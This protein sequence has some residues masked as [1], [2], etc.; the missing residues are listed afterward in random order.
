MPGAGSIFRRLFRGGAKN[1]D[2]AAELVAR[3]IDDANALERNIADR[4]R[5]VEEAAQNQPDLVP[6]TERQLE[7][8]SIV[9][10]ESSPAFIRQEAR[11]ELDDIVRAADT[12]DAIDVPTFQYHQQLQQIAEREQAAL[13]RYVNSNPDLT[14]Q[15]IEQAREEA[16]A[17]VTKLAEDLR[18]N[19]YGTEQAVA[20][21]AAQVDEAVQTQQA[22]NADVAAEQQA[23]TEPVPGS[24]A[25]TPEMQAN[26][27]YSRPT[28][29]EE[30]YAS[31]PKFEE[32][33]RLSIP[34]LISPDRIIRENITRPGENLVN[35]AAS[36]MQTGNSRIGRFFGRMGTGFSRELGIVPDL[37]TARMQLRGGIEKGKVYSKYHSKCNHKRCIRHS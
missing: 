22:T 25:A 6:K 21:Q 28:T 12:G 5:R 18:N 15:Q 33:G 19:R 14:Q 29:D 7:L 11:Q 35:R 27:G 34:Q 2:E 3:E 9:N 26:N 30:L 23:R 17:R 10:D 24:E 16:Q 31:A 8:E 36:A 37:Q 4:T 32:R 13:N 1:V 20:D